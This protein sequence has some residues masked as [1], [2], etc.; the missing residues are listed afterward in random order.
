MV[1][2]KL[3]L[4]FNAAANVQQS[5]RSA[6]DAESILENSQLFINKGV[7]SCRRRLKFNI[8]AAHVYHRQ[9]Q[10]RNNLLPCDTG[11]GTFSSIKL[12]N[13]TQNMLF[14]CFNESAIGPAR[15]NVHKKSF[16]YIRATK[17][18]K[19]FRN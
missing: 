7:T 15:Q 13:T 17:L 5:A 9:Y 8:T 11:T 3:Q 16:L 12:R 4:R 1:I 2:N 19:N 18:R 6:H 10:T 14:C